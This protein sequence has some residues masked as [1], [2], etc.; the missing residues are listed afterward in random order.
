MTNGIIAF[1]KWRAGEKRKSINRNWKYEF[2]IGIGNRN[3]FV[4]VLTLYYI[5]IS[6]SS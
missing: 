3:K 4:T 2:E 6:R 1:G 5:Q